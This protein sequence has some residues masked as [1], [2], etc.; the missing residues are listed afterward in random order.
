MGRLIFKLKKIVVSLAITFSSAAFS[1]DFDDFKINSSHGRLLVEK[2]KNSI[3][4]KSTTSIRKEQKTVT[5]AAHLH[6]RLQWLQDPFKKNRL[7]KKNKRMAIVFTT[8][9]FAKSGYKNVTFTFY[10]KGAFFWN[11]GI[12]TKIKL[13]A[14]FYLQKNIIDGSYERSDE[15]TSHSF[16]ELKVKNPSPNELNSVNKYRVKIEDSDLLQ[17]FFTKEEDIEKN[18]QQIKDRLLEQADVKKI[19]MIEAMFSVIDDLTATDNKFIKPQIAIS[20]ERTAKKY[21]EEKYRSKKGLIKRTSFKDMEY[22]LTLDQNI[23]GYKLSS[24]FMDDCS[25]F[26]VFFEK[27]KDNYV[28]EY[29]KDSIVVEIKVPLSVANLDPKSYSTVHKRIQDE[30]IASVFTQEALYPGFLLNKG[31]ASHFKKILAQKEEI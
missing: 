24:N 25:S 3:E 18:L 10:G 16:L 22:Q 2:L 29:P 27:N 6:E 15:M 19:K 11:L 17:L 14:R 5:H 21:L 9:D 13:R 23:K 20:Y 12:K 26:L 30:F 7:F 28:Y 31:K 4:K 1:N 8:R